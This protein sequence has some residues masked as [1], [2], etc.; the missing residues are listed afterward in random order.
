MECVDAVAGL[1]IASEASVFECRASRLR[2]IGKPVVCQ[3]SDMLAEDHLTKF[4]YSCRASSVDECLPATNVSDP[5]RM[6][7][8]I[9]CPMVVRTDA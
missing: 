6:E 8:S 2:A 7:S 3:I 1:V 4:S 9:A 5:V